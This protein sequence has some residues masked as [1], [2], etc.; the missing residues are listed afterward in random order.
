MISSKWHI[1]HK[2]IHVKF[3][4]LLHILHALIWLHNFLINKEFQLNKNTFQQMH[5]MP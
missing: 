3:S 4:N 2:P 1:L 5:R